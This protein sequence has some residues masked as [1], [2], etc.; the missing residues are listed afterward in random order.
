M[1]QPEKRLS[2]VDVAIGL[3]AAL[4][5][6]SLVL[7]LLSPWLGLSEEYRQAGYLGTYLAAGIF[8][9]CLA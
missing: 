4:L 1:V 7:V 3:I 8:A 5:I 9:I 6:S 2:L